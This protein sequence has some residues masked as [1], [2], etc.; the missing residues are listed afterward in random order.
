MVGFCWS[1]GSRR[2][3]PFPA[4]GAPAVS[5]GVSQ[6]DEFAR[7]RRTITGKEGWWAFQ[8]MRAI[9]AW[10]R[11][12]VPAPLSCCPLWG[13]C[14]RAEVVSGASLVQGRCGTEQRPTGAAC[15]HGDG[16]PKLSRW[17]SRPVAE[18]V[19]GGC[20]VCRERS[21]TLLDSEWAVAAWEKGEWTFEIRTCCIHLQCCFLSANRASHLV[22]PWESVSCG[23]RL[24]QTWPRG[25]WIVRRW[26]ERVNFYSF[27][28]L[29]TWDCAENSTL[30]RG[31]D[32]LRGH[33]VCCVGWSWH[34]EKCNREE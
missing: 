1:R 17:A 19:S 20:E 23:K 21:I 31:L 28:G 9:P 11:G 33:P 29:S 25:C 3:L 22:L 8:P 13:C 5:P 32:R 12:F 16:S 14:G 10:G 26:W 6:V 2:S 4:P 27:S 18:G 24:L 30:D 7:G 15:A 34:W